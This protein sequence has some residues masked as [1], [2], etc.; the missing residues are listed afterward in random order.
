MNSDIFYTPDQILSDVLPLVG[1]EDM[2]DRSKGYY[3]SQMQRALEELS[4]DT[5]FFI[6]AAT[7]TIPKNL[8][9]NLPDDAFSVRQMYLFNGD[10]CDIERAANV[11]W[12]RNFER[13]D[14]GS[15]ERDSWDNEDPFYPK[16]GKNVPSNLHYYNIQNGYIML[17]DSCAKYEKLYIQYYG[18]GTE[19]GEEP[20]VPGFM[21]QAVIDFVAKQALKVKIPISQEPKRWQIQLQE[22]EKSLMGQRTYEEGSWYKAEKRAKQMDRKQREDLR[23]Y[24]A[25]MQY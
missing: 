22:V 4:Y 10:H 25:R 3:L 24:L 17:S 7:R 16:R 8:R 20:I 23:E 19:I 21:R 14:D 2:R 15:V 11:W 1:D 6:R 12:K 9:I 18:I 5:F 13:W